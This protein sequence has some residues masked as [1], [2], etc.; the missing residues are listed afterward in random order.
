MLVEAEAAQEAIEVT[1]S[2]PRG[3]V[4]MSCPVALL[5]A[6]VG[7]MIADFMVEYPRVEV[8]LDATNR[9]STSSRRASTSRSACVRRRCRTATW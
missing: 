5:D 1:R 8:H 7:E 9:R 3:I 6:R 2:E 4:R